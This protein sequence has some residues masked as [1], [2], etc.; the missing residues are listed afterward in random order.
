MEV[1]RRPLMLE[2]I[3]AGCMCKKDGAV[4]GGPF[5][6]YPR[7]VSASQSGTRE[8]HS[9][10]SRLWNQGDEDRNPKGSMAVTWVDDQTF[11]QPVT[12]MQ[13]F[14]RYSRGR[15]KYE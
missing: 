13:A 14:I 8:S 11:T 7:D 1:Y 5:F 4:G 9:S 6:K 15:G 2:S 3:D 10:L 12:E